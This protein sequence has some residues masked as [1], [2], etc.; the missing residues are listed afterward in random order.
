MA[1]ATDALYFANM[2]VITV[3]GSGGT[4]AAKTL[5][6]VK[7]VKASLKWD[8]V[9]AWGWGSIQIQGRAKHQQKV[10]VEI[11]Y[12]KYAP[13]LTE[14]WPLYIADSATGGGTVTDTNKVTT[15]T[16]T[17]QFEPIDATGTVKLLETITGVSFSELPTEAKE[18]DW[19]RCNLKGTGTTVVYSNPA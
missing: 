6:V 13:K 2:G 9:L 18:G 11:E 14:W 1:A 16:V 5:A 7:N 10:D 4:P 15:F 12:M 17:A 19:I 3:A 8:E